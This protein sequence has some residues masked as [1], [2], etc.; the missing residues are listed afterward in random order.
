MSH[1]QGASPQK[2]ERI[3]AGVGAGIVYL[4]AAVGT[5]MPGQLHRTGGGVLGD[6]LVKRLQTLKPGFSPCAARVARASTRI[7]RAGCNAAVS[8]RFRAITVGA[9]FSEAT[10]VD[11]S[12]GTVSARGC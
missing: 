8:A 3:H 7:R 5:H 6:E 2:H 12:S 10:S 4:A 1:S 11:W 9:D